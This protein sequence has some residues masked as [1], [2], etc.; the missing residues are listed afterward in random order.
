MNTGEQ[1]NHRGIDL[2][3]VS[4]FEPTGMGELVKL[5]AA[6]LIVPLKCQRQMV[7]PFTVQVLPPFFQLLCA[8]SFTEGSAR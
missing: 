2:W 1:Q 6:N 7:Q 4:P 8:S 3:L 5:L